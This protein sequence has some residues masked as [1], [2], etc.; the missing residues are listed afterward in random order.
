MKNILLI[1]LLFS[2]FI[3]KSDS[4]SKLDMSH[5]KTFQLD[6]VY[7]TYI[8]SLKDS[9][10]FY[11]SFESQAC[12]HW[13]LQTLKIVKKGNEYFSS[14]YPRKLIREHKREKGRIRTIKLTE[15]QIQRIRNFQLETYKYDSGYLGGTTTTY[16]T[17]KYK[18]NLLKFTDSQ[19]A[20]ERFRILLERLY[21]KAK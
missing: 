2:A 17:F 16:S 20:R 12:K 14:L 7:D 1:P 5:D 6:S 21:G 19:E 13:T 10:S 15:R 18:R 4:A 9:E 11:I 3:A 8:D